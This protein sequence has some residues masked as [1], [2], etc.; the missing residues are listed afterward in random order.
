MIDQPT[1]DEI[2]AALIEYF[3]T[4]FIERDLKKTIKMFSPQ[5]SGFG[6][7]LDE[8]AYNADEFQQ[9]YLR[10]ITQAPNKVHYT[11]NK[12]H[13]TTTVKSVSIVSCELSIETIIQ[14]QKLSLNNFRLSIVFMKNGGEWLIEHM[15]ISLPTLEHN[16]KESYPIKEL[17]DRNRVL[18]RLVDEKTEVLRN[19]NQELRKTL[20]EVKTLRGILPICSHCKKIRTD[21]DSWSLIEAYITRHSEA[22]F[23]HSVCPDCAQKHYP[24]YH[25]YGKDE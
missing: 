17:E 13:I 20:N 10:D 5:I 23:S 8:K 4:Y 2:H 22:E 16:E 7:G 11:I 6:S 9:L 18:Q 3:N 21:D 1:Y 15:H 19:K 24:E 12:L 14:E 25:L